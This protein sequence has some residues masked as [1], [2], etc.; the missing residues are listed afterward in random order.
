VEINNV[1]VLRVG[2]STQ[3]KCRQHAGIGSGGM[4]THLSPQ[5]KTDISVEVRS[6][7]KYIF[8]AFPVH[9]RVGLC[10]CCCT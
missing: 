10:G 4:R 2:K 7:A 1:Q 9:Y 6:S 8:G 3:R 5:E